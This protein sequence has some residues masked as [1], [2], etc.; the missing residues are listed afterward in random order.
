MEEVMSVANAKGIPLTKAN[1]EARLAYVDGLPG[2][3]RV[4]M[5]VDRERGK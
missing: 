1:V 5:A 2:E 3:V 4:S